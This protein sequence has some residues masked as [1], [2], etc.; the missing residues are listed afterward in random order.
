MEEILA[1]AM[2]EQRVSVSVVLPA[3][4]V[5]ATSIVRATVSAV[6]AADLAAVT[7]EQDLAVVKVETEQA[8]VL[9]TDGV[10]VMYSE[11]LN[12]RNYGNL[13]DSCYESM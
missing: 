3:V 4:T 11:N 2:F 1:I 7:T 6:Q 10:V 9:A 5:L 8:V 13:C 12:R